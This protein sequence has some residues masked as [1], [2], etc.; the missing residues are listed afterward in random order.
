MSNYIE[1]FKSS[2]KY[3][4]NADHLISV[5]FRVVNDKKIILNAIENLSKSLIFGIDSILQF[6]ASTK[7]ARLFQEQR[8]N[9]KLFRMIAENYGINNQEI[10]FIDE[11]FYIVKKHKDSSMEIMNNDKLII[12]SDNSPFYLQPDNVKVYVINTRTILNK[13]KKVIF[14]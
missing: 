12:M 2:E 7:K 5:T 3:L 1:S 10:R 4:V 8:E 14:N 9:M 13:I 11:I 6:E